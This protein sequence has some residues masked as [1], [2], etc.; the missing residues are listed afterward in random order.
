M[1]LRDNL[2]AAGAAT[3]LAVLVLSFVGVSFADPPPQS[4]SPVTGYPTWHQD[5]VNEVYEINYSFTLLALIFSTGAAY[6]AYRATRGPSRSLTGFV[7]LVTGNEEASTQINEFIQFYIN[8]TWVAIVGYLLFDVGKIW[9]VVGALHNLLEVA[10]LIVLQY[11]GR[12]S[13]LSFALYMFAYICLTIILSVYLPW[14]FDAVFFRW[15]GLCSDFGLIVVFVRTYYS[16]KNQLKAFGDG[17]R[18]DLELA[19][20]QRAADQLAQDQEQQLRN[21]AT[22]N[23]TQSVTISAAAPANGSHNPLHSLQSGWKKFV[24]LA[25]NPHGQHSGANGDSSQAP[26]ASHEPRF[27]GVRA[28]IINLV[29]ANATNGRSNSDTISIVALNQ[30]PSIWGVEWHNPD[31]I[32]LL[33]VAAIF[34]VIGNCMTTIWI[35]NTYALSA[36]QIS[37]GVSFPLY[38]YYLYVDNHALRQTKIYLP[39]NSKIKTFI[40]AC[41]AIAGATATVRAGLYVSTH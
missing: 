3:T 1:T 7:T 17:D 34:H 35:T 26:A 41:L 27:G 25:P 18:H 19:K 40:G 4:K 11:G 36:F 28:S 32:L 22:T 39:D 23:S 2:I 8:A 13:S 12:V 38:A 10:L 37:Y 16:T 29:P 33:I 20:A 15:Q 30:N 31:Q 21:G 5:Y 9:A 6:G 24:A 14:P